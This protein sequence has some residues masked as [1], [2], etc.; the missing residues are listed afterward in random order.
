MKKK[1]PFLTLLVLSYHAA[2]KHPFKQSSPERLSCQVSRLLTIIKSTSSGRKVS[3]GLLNYIVCYKEAG[4]I[5]WIKGTKTLDNKKS[6]SHFFSKISYCCRTIPV[7][8]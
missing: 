1:I 3:T 7:Y 5:K 4:G 8:D 2:S 6:V